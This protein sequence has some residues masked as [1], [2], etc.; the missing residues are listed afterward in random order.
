MANCVTCKAVLVGRQRRFCSQRCKNRD[1]NNRLQ[2]HVAQGQR[3][4]ARKRELVA[5]FGGRC[6][7]CGYDRNLAALTWHHLDPSN[8]SFEID[9]RA[10]SNRSQAAIEAKVRKC[11]LLCANCHAEEH[12]PQLAHPSGPTGVTLLAWCGLT[13][14]T[15]PA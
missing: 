4:L 8:K 14:T 3:G 1:T 6:S 12:F 2:N 9:L 10:L 5:R 13:P 11:R 7:R 15:A